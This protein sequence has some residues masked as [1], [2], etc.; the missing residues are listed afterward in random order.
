MSAA[1]RRLFSLCKNLHVLPPKRAFRS[2]VSNLSAAI[3]S[4]TRSTIAAVVNDSG[5]RMLKVSWED[6]EHSLYPHI[7]LRD[8]CQ[9]PACFHPDTL[10]RQLNTT[11]TVDFNIRPSDIKHDVTNDLITVMWPD[12]HRSVFS[13]TW[14]RE[15]VF[16]KDWDSIKDCTGL[17]D[18]QPV[19]WK[20][21]DIADSL[22]FMEYKDICEDETALFKH[23]ENLLTLGLSI[24]R[25]APRDKTVLSHLA[26]LMSYTIVRKTNYG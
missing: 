24:V 7:F 21:N 20:R 4:S 11:Y 8:N 6:G 16:P 9:C 12:N 3:G 22:P 13:A 10:S 18:H 17:K 25:N 15:R 23:L 26:K 2:T 19:A 5:E 1:V 14:L